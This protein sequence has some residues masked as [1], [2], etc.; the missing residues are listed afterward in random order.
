MVITAFCAPAHAALLR[1]TQRPRLGARRARVARPLLCAQMPADSSGP[2]QTDAS[3]AQARPR[4]RVSRADDVA[5]MAAAERV[6]A[7]G[8]A[9]LGPLSEDEEEEL[10]AD[11][12][13]AVAWA[14]GLPVGAGRVIMTG[15]NASIERL[16]VLPSY[17]GQGAGRALVG[18][19]VGVGRRAV[20]AT[21]VRARSVELGFYSVLGFEAQ[22]PEVVVRGATGRVMV[23]RVP[24]CAPAAGCVGLHHTSIRVRDIERSLA[25]YGVLGFVVTDK[26]V[27]A[28]GNRACFVEGLGVRLEFVESSVG[29]APAVGAVDGVPPF[30]AAGF[31][32][33]VFDVT[34]ACTDL[35]TYIAHLRKRNGGYLNVRGAPATQVTGKYVV[36]VATIEDVDGLPVEFIRREA[37]VPSALRTRVDW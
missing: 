22:G 29:G 9:E 28:G 12:C 18:A 2:R 16:Y 35:D 30:S 7:A 21:Y 23:L 15:G 17:R 36:S 37:N 1:T 8:A 4:V 6:W 25:F 34:R 10:G 24:E 33:L 13:I 3:G 27:T 19:L 5:A 20:G 26:F 31:D 32:R 14:G 11:D